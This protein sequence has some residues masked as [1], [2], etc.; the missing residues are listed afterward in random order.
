MLKRESI[1]ELITKQNYENIAKQ[2]F[3]FQGINANIKEYNSL[4]KSSVKESNAFAEVV[5]SHNMKLGNYLTSL[6]GANAGLGGYIK[7]LGIAKLKTIAL[8]IATTALN[9]VIGAIASA[10][11]S[12]IMSTMKDAYDYEKSIREKTEALNALEKQYSAYQ[13]DNSEEGKKN[14]Q[15]LKDQI[16]SAKDD[17]KD[18][19]YE[20]LISD[21]E[22]ILDLLQSDVKSWIDQRLDQ[23]DDLIQDII[24]HSNENASDISQTITSTAENYGYNLSKP[25]LFSAKNVNYGKFN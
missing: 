9:M 24:E 16:N 2:S 25:L 15:Q 19:E 7:S 11:A 10:I 18:T 6:N 23:L 17:L 12:F 20:K 4:L 13:G 22:K 1:N 5:A 21:T 14:I 3:S 8:S